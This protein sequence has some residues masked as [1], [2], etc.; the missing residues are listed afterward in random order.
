MGS[1]RVAH[2]PNTAGDIQGSMSCVMI[3][4]G[5]TRAAWKA[6]WIITIETLCP[7]DA[8]RV[9]QRNSVASQAGQS[10]LQAR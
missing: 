2:L 7:T 6:L 8:R 5:K 4:S 10:N 1:I 9:G 3:K